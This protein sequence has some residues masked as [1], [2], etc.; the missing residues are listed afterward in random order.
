M[1]RLFLLFVFM[2][3]LPIYGA[4]IN[5]NSTMSESTIQGLI[6][7]GNSGDTVVFA[8]GT[9]NLAS[10]GGNPNNAALNIKA[11]LLYTGPTSGSPAHLIGTGLYPLMYFTGTSVN[12]QFIT[13]DNGLLFL[14]DHS[15]SVTVDNNIFE[16]MPVCNTVASQ[17]TAIFINGGINNSDISFNTFSHIG[18][19]CNAIQNDSQGA[20]GIG[21]FAFHNLTITHNSFDH[22]HE[23]IDVPIST[24]GS[25][26]CAG[27]VFDYNTFTNSHRMGIEL[28]G[29]STKPSG[30]EV[31]FNS[32]SLPLNPYFPSFGFS[33]TAGLNMI[34]HDNVSNSNSATTGPYGVEIAGISTQAYNNTVEGQWAA[35]F[36]IGNTTAISITNNNICGPSMN[37][38][39]SSGSTPSVGNSNGFI[40]WQGSA[41]AGPNSFTGNTT[42][43]ASTCPA[44]FPAINCPPGT[45]FNTNP[46]GACSVA[47]AGFIDHSQVFNV[48]SVSPALSGTA[49]DLIPSGTTHVAA[50]LIYQSPLNVQA[51]VSTFTFIGNGNNVTFTLQNNSNAGGPCPGTGCQSFPGGA[52]GEAGCSQAANGPTWVPT[53]TVCLELDF[54]DPLTNAG[55]FTFSSAQLYQPFQ[56]PFLP[57]NNTAGYIAQYPTTKLSSSPVSMTQAGAAGTCKQTVGGTCDTFSATVTYD[58]STVTLNLFNMTAGGSC[59]GASCFTQTWTNVS[60]PSIVGSTTAYVTIT[61]GTGTTTTLPLL[62]NSLV[63]TV[64]TPTGSPTFTAWNANSTYNIGTQ[65][66]ASPVYSLVPGTY[67]GTQSITITTSRTP[68]NYICYVL[69]AS[70]PTF[71]PQT[72]NNGGCASGTLYTAPISISS[73]ATLYAMAGSNNTAFGTGVASPSGL[74]PPSTLVAGIYTIIP[75][76]V[77]LTTTQPPYGWLVMP[78]AA[79]TPIF[80]PGGSG[81]TTK[82]LNYSVTGGATLSCI[83]NCLP[84]VTVTMPSSGG[85]CSISGSVGSY[86]LT[87]TVQPVLTAISVDNPSASVTVPFNVCNTTVDAFAVAEPAYQQAYQGQAKT[88]QSYVVGYINQAVTWSITTAPGGG[89]ATLSDTGNRDTVFNSGTVT[90]RY[91][92]TATS[93]ANGSVTGSAIVY[94]S[95]NSLPSYSITLNKTEPTEC[96]VD[97]AL[98]GTDYEVGSGQAF[99]NLA[100]LPLSSTWSVG[101][102][103]RIHPGIY[104]N[105][106]AIQ[107]TGTDTQPLV[108]CGIADSSGNLPIIDGFN[109]TANAS[110]PTSLNGLGGFA[111]TGTSSGIGQGYDLG[112]VGPDYVTITGLQ[113][114]RF[115]YPYSYHAVPSGTL[116]PYGATGNSA[117]GIWIGS[118]QR[119]HMEGLDLEDDGWGVLANNNTG[120]VGTNNGRRFTAFHQFMGGHI[121]NFSQPGSFSNH[122]LYMEGI[123]SL[124]EGNLIENP[125]SN[126]SNA[127]LPLYDNGDFIKMR[128]G[129]SIIRYN[130]FRGILT[131]PAV[132][133]PD[134]EDT[135]AFV[136]ISSQLGQPGVANC[137]LSTW[138]TYTSNNITLTELAENQEALAKD[139]FYG[140]VVSNQAGNQAIA[141]LTY[142]SY[143]A[144]QECTVIGYWCTPGIDRSG[145]FYAWGNTFDQPSNWNNGNDSGVFLTANP[146]T[147]T[148]VAAAMPIQPTIFAANN[149]WWN[150][151]TATC[152]GACFPFTVNVDATMIATF[153]TNMSAA[154]ALPFSGTITGGTT[155]G[156]GGYTNSFSF[157][158][159]NPMQTHLSGLTS[160]NFL[161]TASIPYNRTT[162]APVGSS[163]LINAGF[164]I[165]LAEI[166]KMPVRYQPLNSGFMSARTDSASSTPTIGAVQTGSL[167]TISSVVIPPNPATL[168]IPPSSIGQQEFMFCVATYS[169]GTTES[170]QYRSQPWAS[171]NNTA[172][173]CF[174]ANN[175]ACNIQAIGTGTI[176]TTF[177]GTSANVPFSIAFPISGT[178]KI[179]GIKIGGGVKT[180]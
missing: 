72:D 127:L 24:G 46:S 79:R 107:G 180:Q 17:T 146:F 38:N 135:V 116:T 36:S 160:G 7:S 177:A 19:N 22:V 11:G 62:V 145:Q 80:Y 91:V 89:N 149:V 153:Q 30:L 37:A 77:T 117:S 155:T 94:V 161:T 123:Y 18:D 167:P 12:I 165:T 144:L 67:S 162:F 119:I 57:I 20:G 179:T 50:A 168:L 136:D 111:L 132:W 109:A 97:P 2:L 169:D 51:F 140:N 1:R 8:S 31:A 54:F 53:K 82:L 110:T 100:A 88:L 25:Y 69:S 68:N 28:L 170:C 49:L 163:A 141:L 98:T 76:T 142:G 70:T 32:F 59:P 166:S 134:M 101:S 176:S 55:S 131:G 87:S 63:Y 73:T 121:N 4:T 41:G 133:Y 60:I 65:S 171:S 3:T 139:Y 34:F 5:V 48:R 9:Y 158:L 6:N 137:S 114:K 66:A 164:Q 172:M 159:A 23:G 10:N 71:Y 152:G 120:G 130:M 42:S 58:G 95:P 61:G 156:W 143:S 102:I 85:T 64:N 86:A 56:V 39:P 151:T 147:S 81:A 104:A 105:W 108:I 129:A 44:T 173:D 29:S 126:I 118:G 43:S 52:G 40:S 26:D 115:N 13:F 106:M 175:P 174:G 103:V 96:Y 178:I 27:G 83:S 15:T 124:V 47:L 75:G 21:L 92:I 16:N 148:Y 150:D 35:G 122:G 138:C 45:G 78:G 74:G 154:G 90:G 33:L 112:S 84:E 93:V 99:A 14:E 157:P 128:G 125:Q 113:I